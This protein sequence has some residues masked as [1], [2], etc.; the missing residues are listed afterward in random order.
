MDDLVKIFKALG[1]E[2]RLRIVAL[3]TC[4]D[5][6]CACQMVDLFG[7]SGATIS[8]HLSVLVQAGLLQSRKDGR[9]IYYS[10]KPGC[11][12]PDG[13]RRQLFGVLSENR[14][15]VTDCGAIRTTEMCTSQSNCC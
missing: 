5:E 10:L 15:C 2:T 11:P 1:D 3:L 8:R 4:N 14:V 7:L 9:W 12:L 6:L 13:L